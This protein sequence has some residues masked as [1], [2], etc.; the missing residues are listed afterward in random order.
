M[1]EFLNK[2]EDLCKRSKNKNIIT[3][4]GFLTPTERQIIIKNFSNEK[5]IFCGGN[6][7]SE[8]VRAFFLPDYIDEIEKTDYITAFCARF[9]YK[10][11][12]HRD[13]L[14]SILGLGIDRKCIGDIFVFE[15]E[16]YFFVTKDISEY[17][18]INLNKVGSVGVKISEI[19]IDEV[20]VIEPSFKEINFS[21]S[22]LR[23][24]SILAGSI[25]ES[26]EKSV[27]YIK[28][29]VVLLNYLP[30]ENPSQKVNEDD[31]FSIK[32]YGKFKIAEIGGISRRGKTFVKVF[33]YI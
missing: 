14:G 9:S 8:R 5:I 10:E 15:K 2:I 22:S 24:D 3:Y 13:F 1:E 26:R 4:T 33:K 25:M 16:A 17:I 20:K 32:G 12:T 18:K 21:V 27:N 7:N 11:L 23:L 30:C 28:N 31:I 6:N 19:N 29:G